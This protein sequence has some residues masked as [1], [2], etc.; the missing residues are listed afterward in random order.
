MEILDD[1]SLWDNI[2]IFDIYDDG[3]Q[4]WFASIEYNALFK[5]EK[6]NNSIDFV[7]CFPDEDLFGYRLYSSINEFDSKL[8]FTPCSACE[9]GVYD[10]RKERFEKINIGILKSE[11]NMAHIKYS[12]KFVSSFILNNKL[13][14]MPCCYDKMII[15]DLITGE[16]TFRDG[17]FDYFYN[18]YKDCIKSSDAQFYL[19]WFAKKISKSVIVFNLHCNSNIIIFYNLETDEFKEKR[20]GNYERSYSLIDFD[21]TYIF[22]YDEIVDV[23]VRFDIQRNEY[24]ECVIKNELEEFMPCGMN[25]SFVNMITFDNDLYLIPANTNITVKLDILTWKPAVESTLSDE[26]LLRQKCIAYMN[27]CRVFNNR[28]YLFANRS[29]SIIVYKR[30]KELQH[31][32]VKTTPLIN[33]MIQKSHLLNQLY[34]NNHIFDENNICLQLFLDTIKEFKNP[35]RNFSI[36]KENNQI[37]NLGHKIYESI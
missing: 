16:A 3:K 34:S 27:L 2:S 21:G 10:M 9:I 20:I 12:K 6:Q 18:K 26:C 24:K 4:L 7:G 30:E 5:V 33:M 36:L 28:L 22:L 32:K 25:H 37:K 17:L 14:L 8:Y 23:V 11:N 13:I 19:C 31:I 35:K 1:Y 15:Y 29:K